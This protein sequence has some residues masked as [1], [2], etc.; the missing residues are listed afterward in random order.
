MPVQELWNIS[1][2]E[3]SEDKGYGWLPYDYIRNEIALDFWSLL[4]QTWVVTGIFK[5]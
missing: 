5:I 1:R 4:N 3:L 2:I